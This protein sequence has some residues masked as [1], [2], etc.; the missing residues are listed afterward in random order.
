MRD[1]IELEVMKDRLLD[2]V[3]ELRGVAG[4]VLTLMYDTGRLVL[5]E[6]KTL[7]VLEALSLNVGRCAED[8]DRLHDWLDGEYW[9]AKRAEGIWDGLGQDK[10]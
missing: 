8:L 1:N 6:Q 10:R 2:I 3:T 7:D 9:A 5:S 4:I